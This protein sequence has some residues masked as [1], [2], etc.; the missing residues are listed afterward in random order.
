[1]RIR[2]LAAA[3]A[4]ALLTIGPAGR[5]VSAQIRPEPNRGGALDLASADI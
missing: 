3:V 2:Y 5:F 1:M 4:A